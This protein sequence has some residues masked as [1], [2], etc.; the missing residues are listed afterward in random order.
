MFGI[1][2]IKKQGAASLFF[3][4]RLFFGRI[5]TLTAIIKLSGQARNHMPLRFFC[6]GGDLC[7]FTNSEPV[8]LPLCRVIEEVFAVSNAVSLKFAQKFYR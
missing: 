7:E 4:L 8:V 5:Y 1:E 3:S 2:K 6:E